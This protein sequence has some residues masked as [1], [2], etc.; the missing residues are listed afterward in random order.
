MLCREYKITLL[1]SVVPLYNVYM[2]QDL[3]YELSS[4]L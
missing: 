1:F 4:E 3:D 2:I